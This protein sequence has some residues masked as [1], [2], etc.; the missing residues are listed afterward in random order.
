MRGLAQH[1]R[2]LAV[3]VT[4]ALFGTSCFAVT[5]L[6]RFEAAKSGNFVD[7]KFT[8]RGMS[9]H[10]NEY[11]EYRVVDATNTIQSR[12]IL[13]P[14][15]GVQAEV[16]VPGAVPRQNGP[17]RLDFYADHDASGAYDKLPVFTDHAWRLDL[18]DDMLDAKNTFDIVFDHNTSFTFL[19]DQKPREVGKAFTLRFANAPDLVGKRVQARVRDASSLRVVALHRMT[20]VTKP[21][22]EMT[23]PGMIERG[24]TYTI[25]VYI[26]DGAATP[27][28]VV[29]F[30]TNRDSG[31]AG[32]VVDFD[33]KAFTA[34]TTGPP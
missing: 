27:A 3:A 12:G 4:A 18:R 22:F 10:V 29:G 6:D 11:F 19:E 7:L 8:V 15:G 9:S 32:L 17:F 16:F 5:D 13:L 2:G 34:A 21:A 14:L 33:P 31:E 1:A 26:D 20:K 24:V 28:S 25:E 23:V 30:R